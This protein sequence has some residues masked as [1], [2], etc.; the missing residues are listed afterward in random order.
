MVGYILI[1]KINVNFV[2]MKKQVKNRNSFNNNLREND[3]IGL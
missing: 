1:G 2:R 3:W